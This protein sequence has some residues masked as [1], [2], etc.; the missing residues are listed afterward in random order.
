MLPC[1]EPRECLPMIRTSRLA[2]MR[3]LVTY[4]E[5]SE[6]VDRWSG[7]VSVIEL[8][9]YVVPL[10]VATRAPLLTI[11]AEVVVARSVSARCPGRRSSFSGPLTCSIRSELEVCSELPHRL[12]FPFGSPRNA[13]YA[14]PFREI[15][16]QPSRPMQASARKPSYFSSNSQSGWSNASRRRANNQRFQS[17]RRTQV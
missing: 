2:L 3:T 12:R 13:L 4:G 10:P 9:V 16:R 5:G 8:G 6:N 7:P 1:P 14:F 11:P 17:P 15:S